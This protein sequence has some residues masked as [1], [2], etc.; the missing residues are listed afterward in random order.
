M[1]LS[2]LSQLFLKQAQKA[3][4]SEEHKI[5]ADGGG[6]PLSNTAS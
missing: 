2:Q 6:S 3:L 1:Q 4:S 5:K